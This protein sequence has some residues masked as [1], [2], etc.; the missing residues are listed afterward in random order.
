MI[1]DSECLP[2]YLIM[3]AQIQIIIII[4]IIEIIVIAMNDDFIIFN[5]VLI[6]NSQLLK[7]SQK[8]FKRNIELE[9]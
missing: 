1:A 2:I 8:F 5:L 4:I 6:N 9:I 3:E 7:N